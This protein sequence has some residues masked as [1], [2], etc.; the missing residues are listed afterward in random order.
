MS[1]IRKRLVSTVQ[2][3][4]QRVLRHQLQRQCLEIVSEALRQNLDGSVSTLCAHRTQIVNLIC[5]RKWV[6][7]MNGNL[8][9]QQG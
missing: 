5:K 1:M 8:P 3:L 9:V 7:E 4:Q 6:K 2:H